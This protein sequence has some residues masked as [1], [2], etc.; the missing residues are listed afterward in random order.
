[1]RIKRLYI[2]KFR[3]LVDFEWTIENDNPI[4]VIIGKNGSGKSNLLEAIAAIFAY[5][6]HL[7]G[8][9]EYVFKT[10]FEIELINSDG[11]ILKY[12]KIED[13][14]DVFVNTIKYP[15]DNAKFFSKLN[16]NSKSTQIE[17]NRLPNLIINYYQGLINRLGKISLNA[18]SPSS[19][20]I[21]FINLDLIIN[22][23]I[24]LSLFASDLKNKIEFLRKMNIVDFTEFQFIVY[25][26]DNQYKKTLMHRILTP[27]IIETD[28][29]RK[30]YKGDFQVLQAIMQSTLVGFE[31]V[32]FELLYSLTQIND[33]EYIN[34]FFKREGI[35]ELIE[36]DYLS[37]G[38]KQKLAIYGSMVLFQDKE[39]I[40][41]LDEPDTFAHPSWQW[42]LI[43]E[44]QQNLDQKSQCILTTHSPL[45]LSTVKENA[46]MM[47]D[48]KIYPLNETFG[49]DANASLINM[50]VHNISEHVTNDFNQ[51]FE[52]IQSGEGEKKEAIQMRKKLEDRYGLNHFNFDKADRLIKFYK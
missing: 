18:N 24:L 37:E 36:Y 38:E 7:G 20:P 27:C 51:Y 40:F 3:N 50:E 43:P 52:L 34:I 30:I 32:L 10:N 29:N 33:F 13:K 19:P 14:L 48:G 6:N 12:S 4:V 35:P 1:M 5:L 17:G 31:S 21:Y 25:D 11:V 47:E 49:Q 42:D 9:K 8:K 41:L 45:V 46:F 26:I 15:N 28:G 39:N 22:K 2:K 16:N 23:V 44:L